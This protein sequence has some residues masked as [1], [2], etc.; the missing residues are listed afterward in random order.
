MKLNEIKLQER[1]A[2]GGVSALDLLKALATERNSLEIVT[3]STLGTFD[4]DFMARERAAREK[5]DTAEADAAENV[6][7]LER[8][9]A[10]RGWKTETRVCDKCGK[11]HAGRNT[12]CA[13]CFEVDDGY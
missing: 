10:E 4:A 7:L 3:L 9:M 12:T 8:L 13:N 6:Q 5:L 2:K 11:H 1:I